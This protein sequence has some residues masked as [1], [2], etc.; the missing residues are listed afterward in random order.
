VWIEGGRA[1]LAARRE[2]LADIT[3]AECFE[4]LG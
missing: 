2:T 3:R 1:Y 4:P